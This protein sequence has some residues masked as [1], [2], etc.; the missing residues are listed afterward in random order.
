MCPSRPERIRICASQDL[1]EGAHLKLSVSYDGQPTSVLVFRHGGHSRAFKNLCV[2][3]PRA[4]DCEEDMIFDK[5]GRYLRCSMH[6]IVYDPVSGESLSD[7]CYGQRLT[8]VE[9][10]EDA[11]G[12]WIT[13]RHVSALVEAP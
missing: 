13:D 5:S 12:I 10:E 3:M 4:L 8:D 1:P 2:H 6:G 9:I 7:I 11:D